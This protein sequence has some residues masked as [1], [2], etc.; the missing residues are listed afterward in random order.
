MMIALRI[1]LFV[2]L[3]VPVAARA[4]DEGD[5]RLVNG[6]TPEEGRVEVFHAGQWGTV[7]DDSWDL[8]DAHVACRQLGLGFAV[9]AVQE[10]GF[11]QGADPIWMDDVE[12]KGGESRLVECPFL[13]FGVH[14]CS[15]F[16]D[17]GVICSGPGRRVPAVSLVG[18]TAIG[19][20][21]LGGGVRM[22]R[23]RRR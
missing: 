16:E 13:G 23:R 10:A 6:S 2:L 11:G 4:Q 8:A 19:L 9:E 15:H 21:L 7:C 20:A 14:N 1:G 3:L 17:A 22:L 12:C 18:L 5:L